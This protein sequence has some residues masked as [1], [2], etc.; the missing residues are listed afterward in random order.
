MEKKKPKRIRP[1]VPRYGGKYAHSKKI[2]AEFPKHQTYLEPFGGGGSVLLSKPPSPV[3]TYNDLDLQITRI[4]RVLRKNGQ[5]FIRQLQVTPY[6][7]V[8]FADA[9]KLT[10]TE[11]EKAVATFI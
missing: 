7:E 9:A 10:G 6:S 4:F 8:E 3:E 11:V 2:I 1:P 5:E